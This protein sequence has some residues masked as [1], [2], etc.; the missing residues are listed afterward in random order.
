ML[1]VV[2][3]RLF[4]LIVTMTTV[5]HFQSKQLKLVDIPID[6]NTLILTQKSNRGSQEPVIAHLAFNLTSKLHRKFSA[7]SFFVI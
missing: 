7:D 5:T 2:S 4:P 3:G 6:Y 1:F